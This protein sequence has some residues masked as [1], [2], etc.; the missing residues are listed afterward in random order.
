[1]LNQP[2]KQADE[3]GADTARREQLFDQAVQESWR[4]TLSKCILFDKALLITSGMGLLLIIFFESN[5]KSPASLLPCLSAGLF[6]AGYFASL[7]SLLTSQWSSK[8]N[9]HVVHD[10]Y[11]CENHEALSYSNPAASW[12][13]WLKGISLASIFVGYF[14]LVFIGVL[15]V[16]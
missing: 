5:N 14:I 4:R 10:Y 7:V 16:L 15:K 11:I 8:Q 9:E 12:T 2:N 3:N 1:M 13:R 6:I